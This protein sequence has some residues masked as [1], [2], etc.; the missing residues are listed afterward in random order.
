V[1]S[2]LLDEA[3]EIAVQL[4]LL[5]ETQATLA[6]AQAAMAEACPVISMAQ[7]PTVNAG[8]DEEDSDG[9]GNFGH[10]V[11]VPTTSDE[12]QSLL[13]SLDRPP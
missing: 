11:D 13:A 4:A 3:A 1:V 6:E 12:Q 7:Q 2:L 8:M 5:A 10:E 9:L